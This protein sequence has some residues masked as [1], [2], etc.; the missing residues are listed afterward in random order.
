MQNVLF[1]EGKVFPLPRAI[2]PSRRG[3]LRLVSY[4]RNADRAGWNFS[5]ERQHGSAT[6]VCANTFIDAIQK[7]L[8]SL[9]VTKVFNFGDIHYSVY[10]QTG[11]LIRPASFT[12]LSAQLPQTRLFH[13]ISTIDYTILQGSVV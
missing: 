8:S 4:L 7:F 9:L 6:T 1:R 11:D 3:D 5:L 12:L 13:L 10:I 2:I